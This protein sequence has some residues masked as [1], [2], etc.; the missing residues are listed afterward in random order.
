MAK[1][2]SLRI[3][4]VD[5]GRLRNLLFTPGE[6]ES[7]T[8]LLCGQSLI[9]GEDKLLVRDILAPTPDQYIDRQSYRLEVAPSFYN[10][11]VERCLR[12]RLVPVIC[13]S[14]PV[15]G[16][17]T[18][19]PSDDFG[20]RRL[21]P[22]VE[23]LLPGQ[24]P[25]SLLLTRTSVAGRVLDGRHFRSLGAVTITG[26]R[27]RTLPIIPVRGAHT[28]RGGVFD[29][30]IR[31][32]GVEGQRTIESLTVAVVGL[33]GVGSLIAEQLVRAGFSHL[34]LVDFDVV[35]RSNLN[36]LFGAKSDSVGQPKV[37]VVARH[38]TTIRSLK[39]KPICDSV[40]KQ[41]VLGRLRAA[42]LI[43][44]CVDNDLARTIL[45]RFAHQYLT[46]V[47]DVGLR[48][49]ARKGEVTAAAGRVSVVGPDG[50][51]LRCSHH[52]NPERVRAESL[53]RAEREALVREGYVIGIDEP[54]PAV[55]TLN[56]TMA[57]L[58]ATAALNLFV[59][60]TGAFQPA[61]QLYDAVSGTVFIART[62]H[63]PGCDICDEELGVKALGDSEVVS[64]YD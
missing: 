61:T 19:S 53:P 42:D 38:L 18:Y 40:L 16:P 9:E 5:W 32:F 29:R 52:T 4:G 8:V 46:P 28:S 27:V 31:A 47:I 34:I 2:T 44:S 21:L 12:D 59:N 33:G 51:C 62:V 35:E 57:G 56:C 41:S 11:V 24:K 14:H 64:A 10:S 7:A 1:R 30:Q 50:A 3:S 36:R 60:L 17:A 55:V 54:T 43:L 6:L 58:G 22:V 26:P 20:E 39:V 45:A 15:G 25:A 63:K 37:K 23:S 13:H 48:L 49:D